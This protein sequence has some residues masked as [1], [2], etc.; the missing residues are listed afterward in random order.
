[1]QKFVREVKEQ[2][3]NMCL[4]CQVLLNKLI[5]QIMKKKTSISCL[6]LVCLGCLLMIQ[7]FV[8][9]EETN[10]QRIQELIGDVCLDV[11]YQPSSSQI[12]EAK[13]LRDELLSTNKR[14][15]IEY[16]AENDGAISSEQQQ[17]TVQAIGNML[18]P[19]VILFIISFF[20][21]ITLIICCSDCCPCR[22]CRCTQA[23]KIDDIR[24]SLAFS[25]LFGVIIL[26]FCI[27][28]LIMSSEVGNSIKS[29]RCA[30]IM[31]FSDINDGVTDSDDDEIKRWRGLD[32]VI[33]NITTIQNGLGG[34]VS[35]TQ[36]QLDSI[37]AK[38]LQDQFAELSEENKKLES[39]PITTYY[40]TNNIL[41]YI[42]TGKTITPQDLQD[43]VK[44]VKVLPQSEIFKN[45]YENI[46]KEIA[47]IKNYGQQLADQQGDI[48]NS[49]E[50]TKSSIQNTKQNLDKAATD[51]LDNTENLDNI[52]NLAQLIFY[53]IYGV[54]GLFSLIITASS[55]FLC[56]GKGLKC[57]KCLLVC[58][59]TF[60]FLFVLI[61]FILS[62]I[63]GVT[64]GVFAEGCD[65]FDVLLTNQTKFENLNYAVQDKEIKDIMTIC[66]FQDGDILN[67]YKVYDDLRQAIDLDNSISEFAIQQQEF[68][69]QSKEGDATLKINSDYIVS[70]TKF[71]RVDEK[72]Y[73]PPSDSTNIKYVMREQ[74]K[75]CNNNKKSS[76]PDKMSYCDSTA[77]QYQPLSGGQFSN[78]NNQ[79]VCFQSAIFSVDQN[80][81]NQQISG[82]AEISIVNQFYT[83]QNTQ[84][85]PVQEQETSILNKHKQNQDALRAK[86]N[87]I[88][89]YTSAA[90]NYLKSITDKNTGAL[91]GVN[92]K[93]VQASITRVQNVMCAQS[94][95]LFYYFWIF[96]SIISISMWLA[97]ISIFRVSIGIYYLSKVEAYLQGDYVNGQQMQTNIPMAIPQQD[98]TGQQGYVYQPE[99]QPIVYENKP[100]P[101]I[102]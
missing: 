3:I 14:I 43:E 98:V 16:I 53:I 82:C 48:S 13:R 41:G 87:A 80:L 46:I 76:V 84:W 33:N 85:K 23:Q 67:Y 29:I 39:I 36:K 102:Q 55:S 57:F 92:C 59:C 75:T 100:Y 32:S 74:I 37:N 31:I 79:P 26:A 77:I 62:A 51:F 69:R 44:Q 91:S 61:G 54:F 73:T 83:N 10:L 89:Q 11:D 20:T 95:R 47:N 86:F 81:L 93:F 6:F 40:G 15:G 45:I 88:N 58:S 96:F 56:F 101:Q 49:L 22:C 35:D 94:F 78:P 99:T 1:M 5:I 38:Q 97:A 21:Y 52:S 28:G 30:G 2:K 64:S 66:L 50:D 71:E 18:L 25:L 63:L 19:W 7:N 90:S 27:A 24:I 34:F 72:E 9:D 8:D 68:E 70:F 4:N 17:E 65:Y 42:S 60:N 12:S